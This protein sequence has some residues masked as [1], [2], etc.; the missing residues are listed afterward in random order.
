MNICFLCRTYHQR[1]GGVET[2]TYEMAKELAKQG[3][4]VHI[5]T[6]AGE[7]KYFLNHTPDS[8][9]IHKVDFKQWEFWG[10]WK[11]DKLFPLSEMKY[12]L[13]L[14]KKIEEVVDKYKIDIIEA[15]DGYIQGLRY[16]LSKNKKSPLIMRIHGGICAL[17]EDSWWTS[18]MSARIKRKVI[19]SLER[20]AAIS[21]DNVSIVS[22]DFAARVHK[23]WGLNDQKFTVIHNAIDAEEYTAG[24]K[25]RKDLQVLFTGRLEERKGMEYLAKAIEDVAKVF[26]DVQFLFAGRNT[27]CFNNGSK[28]W[29]EYILKHAPH[30]N[31]EFLGEVSQTRIIELYQTS[32]IS[33]FP[34]VYEPFGIVA[35][36]AMACGCPTIATKSGGFTEIIHNN[37]EGILIPPR[38]SKALSE[39]IINLLKDKELRKKFSKNGIAKVKN[40]FNFNKIIE[41]TLKS[42]ERTISDTVNSN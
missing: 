17:M 13:D 33:V 41:E 5:I 27:K 42:Y 24:N 1:A 26:P 22:E 11:V 35:L 2:Y 21:A 31:I 39:A 40:K 10:K 9:K 6:E 16:S 19:S 12:S 36:E 4:K 8:V 37:E 25:A 28:T 15:A 38:D 34:S 30:K 23:Y 18:S 3:H 7:E 20:K 14:G 29:Q 32:T